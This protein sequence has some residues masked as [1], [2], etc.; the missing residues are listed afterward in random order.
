MDRAISYFGALAKMPTLLV[1]LHSNGHGLQPFNNIRRHLADVID[2][3]CRLV[4][5]VFDN[6]ARLALNLLPNKTTLSSA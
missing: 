1:G 5:C 3:C 6:K 4:A 2:D